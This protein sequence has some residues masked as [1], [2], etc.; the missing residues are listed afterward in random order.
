MDCQ[1]FRRAHLAFTDGTLPAALH[2]AAQDHVDRCPECARYDC[3]TRRAL[4]LVRNLPRVE[5]KPGFEAR[6]FAR[7]AADARAERI[8]RRFLIGAAAAA[9]A[10]AVA[11]TF[12]PPA[13]RRPVTERI[14]SR[15]QAS[16]VAAAKPGAPSRFHRPALLM[17]LERFS[18][19]PDGSAF[20][21]TPARFASSEAPP[22]TFAR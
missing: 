8:R 17:P 3:R 13:V 19:W 2:L 20:D 12:V 14:A 22:I 4:L 9:A 16:R 18:T 10:V 21:A 15:P 11:A 5:A 6:L 7:I 1:R